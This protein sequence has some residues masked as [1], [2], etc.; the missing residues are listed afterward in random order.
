M[1]RRGR[2]GPIRAPA[3]RAGGRPWS[4]PAGEH[5]DVRLG[6]LLPGGVD[7]QAEHAILGAD[8]AAVVSDEGDVEARDP[9][10]DLV[11]PDGIERGD[12]WE[13][14]DGD[15]QAVG[16]AGVLSIGSIGVHRLQWVGGSVDLR[17]LFDKLS[18]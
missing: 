17:V 8:L 15:L 11:G 14:R 13:E 2:G 18:T 12:V 10:K 9:L 16:H 1:C 6:H 3:R 5:D 4:D 7:G